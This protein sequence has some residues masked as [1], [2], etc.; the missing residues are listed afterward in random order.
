MMKKIFPPRFA[1]APAF[2]LCAFLLTS[3]GGG[4]ST[5]V[6]PTPSTTA[7]LAATDS[8]QLAS[9]VSVSGYT[10][11]SIASRNSTSVVTAGGVKGFFKT[12]WHAL[13]PQPTQR[14]VKLMLIS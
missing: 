8:N 1:L 5:T 11:L 4:G 3:C 7:P 13:F 12:Y 9:E 2:L 14:P 10:A 6:T